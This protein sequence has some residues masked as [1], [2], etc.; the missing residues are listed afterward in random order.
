MKNNKTAIISLSL[1]SVFF[2]L[3]LIL[4]FAMNYLNRRVYIF[5]G[6]DKNREYVE[7]RF[8]PHVK[9]LDKVEL[10]VSELVLGPIGNRYKNLFKPGTKVVSCFVRGKNLYVELSKDALVPEKNTTEF[11]EAVKL[12]KKNIRRNFH[13][14]KNVHIY[15]DGVA[16]GEI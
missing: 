4:Y 9:K 7:D 6:L 11:S 5:Q 14:I 8:Y 16:V 2:I 3:S 12:F 10:Y 1:I 15:I 13:G